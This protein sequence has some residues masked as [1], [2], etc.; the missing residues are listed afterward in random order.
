MHRILG[1]IWRTGQFQH[2]TL[3]TA[4][5]KDN[6]DAVTVTCSVGVS[7]PSGSPVACCCASKGVHGPYV[8]H[9]LK[10]FFKA[11]GSQNL[12]CKSDQ[13]SSIGAM[14]EEA[15]IQLRRTVEHQP[16]VV[17]PEVSA[18]RES[19]SNGIAERA[20][21]TF[22][23]DLRTL[24]SAFEESVGKRLGATHPV[25]QWLVEHA[26]RLRD[27]FHVGKSGLTPY[28]YLHAAR[29]VRRSSSLE[30]R[31]STVCPRQ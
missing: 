28:E 24:K 31:S 15:L 21:Q 1:V 11:S 18:V 29:R 3:T 13:E 10:D 7:T 25:M 6:R 23:D 9:R 16:L 4:S 22:E 8:V 27:G 12:V 5:P 20:V 26:V 14:V 19:Q 17:V 30:K 2:C